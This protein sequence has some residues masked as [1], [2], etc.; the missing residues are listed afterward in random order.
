M[1]KFEGNKQQLENDQSRKIYCT[2]RYAG[3]ESVHI[4]TQ[5]NVVGKY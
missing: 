1:I 2:A 5:E 3:G 4:K